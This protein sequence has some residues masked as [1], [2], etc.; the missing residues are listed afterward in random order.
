MLET[1]HL[2]QVESA[3]QK[4]GIRNCGSWPEIKNLGRVS[5]KIAVCPIF[6]KFDIQDKL[7][8]VIMNIILW[9][10]DSDPNL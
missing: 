9:I 2:E 7:Y 4:Y 5:L 8:M 3:N 1:W 6:I 10:D